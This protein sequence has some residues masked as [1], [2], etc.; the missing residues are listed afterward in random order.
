MEKTSHFFNNHIYHISSIATA[1]CAIF[2]NKKACERFL[3]KL[4]KY[5]SPICTIMHYAFQESGFQCIIKLKDRKTFQKFYRT[6]HELPDMKDKEILHSTFI[7]S[8]QMANLLSSTAIHYNRA[9]GR[10]G[11]LFASRF[12]RKLIEKES[13]LT[14]LLE[15][16]NTMTFELK[17]S[18]KWRYASDK[19]RSQKWRKDKRKL[20]ERCAF[21]YYKKKTNVHEKLCSFKRADQIELRGHFENLPPK[22]IYSTL[23]RL[24]FI[25]YL[26]KR[27]PPS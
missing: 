11:A 21:Y 7:F 17:Y 24:V 12:Q 16:M 15:Q 9:Q 22:S 2:H 5:L 3:K 4:D 6:K 19:E 18:K 10:S 27:K 8:Q 1:R 25:F 26:K 20:K 13:E 23:D 14:H